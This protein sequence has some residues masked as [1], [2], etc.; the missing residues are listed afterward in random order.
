MERPAE[1]LR[2]LLSAAAVRRRAHE[3]LDLALAGKIA[4][5]RVDLDRLAAAADLTAAVTREAYPNLAIPLH[6]R[7]RHF[8]VGEPALPAGGGAAA[9]ARSAFDLVIVSVLLDAGAGPVWRYRDAVSGRTLARSEG[10]AVA[11][12]RLF[13]AGAFSADPAAP[14]RVDG[15]TLAALDEAVLAAG[16]QVCAA[17]LLLG[18]D[19]RTSLLRRLGTQVLARRDLFAAG[20]AP[21]PGG[22]YDIL[23]ARAEGGRLPAPAILE[24]LLEALGP[25]WSGRLT[26]EGVALG[27]CW[28]H[29]ALRRGDATDTLV[30]LHKLSQWLAYSLIEPLQAAGIQVTDMDGLTGLAE[31]RNGG[32]FVDTGVLALTDPADADRAHDVS[33]PLIVAWRAMTVALLDRLAPLVRERLGVDEAAFPLARMLEG[34]TWAAGRRLAAERRPGGGPPFNIHSDGTV[35]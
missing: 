5:W 27:D 19:G 35:F 16:F 28:R 34:G 10:L 4:G 30:P 23:A 17:N 2:R 24:L 20:D 9:R 12:Q 32:L 15:T 25:I 3:M 33:E 14:A 21:R 1:A 13:E 7:A 11:S 29:P 6:A 31:Y 8:V 18:L 26:L 22:L